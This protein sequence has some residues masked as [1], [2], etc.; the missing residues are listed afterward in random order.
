MPYEDRRTVAG[1]GFLGQERFPDH[2]KPPMLS[3][4]FEPFVRPKCTLE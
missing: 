3:G 4:I 2:D 1:Q